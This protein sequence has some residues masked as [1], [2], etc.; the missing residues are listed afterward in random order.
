MPNVIEKPSDESVS[1][2]LQFRGRVWADSRDGEEPQFIRELSDREMEPDLPAI[3]TADLQFRLQFQKIDG[4]SDVS[5]EDVV[6]AYVASLEQLQSFRRDAEFLVEAVCLSH[7]EFEQ[8]SGPTD[9]A[10]RVASEKALLESM[11]DRAGLRLPVAGNMATAALLAGPRDELRQTLG[12]HLQTS[13]STLTRDLFELFNRLV[14]VQLAGLF[15]WSG[16]GTCWYHFFREIVRQENDGTRTD[17]SSRLVSGFDADGEEIWIRRTAITETKA[18][19]DT[20]RLARHEHHVMNAYQTSLENTN[21]VIP[22]PVQEMIVAIPSWL[23]PYISV[24]DGTL[25][26]EKIISR[27]YRTE[28]WSQVRVSTVDLPVLDCEPAVLLGNVVLAGWGPTEIAKELER[29]AE[30]ERL[31][32]A[33]EQWEMAAQPAVSTFVPPV[34]HTAA[35]LLMTMAF[36]LSPAWMLFSLLLSA[37]GFWTDLVSRAEVQ[38]VSGESQTPVR[39]IFDSLGV[40]LLSAAAQCLLTSFLLMNGWL[41][42]GAVGCLVGAGLLRSTFDPST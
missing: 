36:T 37:G 24:I 20:I 17:N 30:E 6:A 34:C 12:E 15:E 11:L 18:G 19:R 14:D 9:Q 5:G 23:A 16:A 40:L 35:I 3:V 33:A 38:R 39:N 32:S 22:L 10:Q 42:L 29:R 25:F 41:L 7:M 31:V 4:L 8:V 26:R 1:V 2:E 21:V 27:D 13:V 28:D